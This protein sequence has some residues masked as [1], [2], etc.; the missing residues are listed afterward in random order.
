LAP[1]ALLA[2]LKAHVAEKPDLNSRIESAAQLEWLG[3]AVALVSKWRRDEGILLQGQVNSLSPM[4][5][6]SGNGI[7]GIYTRIYSA[8]AALELE[9]PAGSGEV[10]AAIGCQ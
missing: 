2:A 5:Y 1:E 6:F 7:T 8:I 9:S 4:H 10:F 3:R